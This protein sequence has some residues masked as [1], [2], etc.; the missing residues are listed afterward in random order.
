[1]AVRGVAAQRGGAHTILRRGAVER[2]AE[3]PGQ[4]GV[5][6]QVD[7]TGLSKD[8]HPTLFSARGREG[9]GQS[10]AA[11]RMPK[12]SDGAGTGNSPVAAADFGQ[13]G[14]AAAAATSIFGDAAAAATGLFG[15]VS[16]SVTNAA[17]ALPVAS[18]VPGG[19]PHWFQ[20]PSSVSAPA[21][22][23]PAPEHAISPNLEISLLG[24]EPTPSPALKATA[25]A[26]IDATPSPAP[27]KAPPTNPGPRTGK[28]QPVLPPARRELELP[29]AHA[30]TGTQGGTAGGLMVAAATLPPVPVAELA[31]TIFPN[32]HYSGQPGVHTHYAGQPAATAVTTPAVAPHTHYPGQPAVYAINTGSGSVDTPASRKPVHTPTSPQQQRFFFPPQPHQQQPRPTSESYHA[33]GQKGYVGINVTKQAPFIVLGASGL[34]DPKGILQGQTGYGNALVEPGDRL[35]RVDGHGIEFGGFKSLQHLLGGELGSVV[36][37]AFSRNNNHQFTIRALRHGGPSSSGGHLVNHH[38]VVLNE[39]VANE[40]V[41]EA[42]ANEKMR[43]TV[44]SFVNAAA[45]PA[46]V[47]EHG[48]EGQGRVQSE[49]V[50]LSQRLATMEREALDRKEREKEKERE[51]QKAWERSERERQLS[52][53][54]RQLEAATTPGAAQDQAHLSK[55][56]PSELFVSREAEKAEARV[57]VIL[58]RAEEERLAAEKAAAA[59]AAAS[60]AAAAAVVELE[61]KRQQM[62]REEAERTEKEAQERRRREE[63][64]RQDAARRKEREDKIDKQ[65][66]EA[67]R[68]AEQVQQEE[69]ARKNE[70]EARN[71]EEERLAAAKREEERLTAAKKEEEMLHKAEMEE[72]KKKQEE[73]RL[74]AVSIDESKTVECHKTEEQKEGG[75]N[76]RELNAMCCFSRM[77]SSY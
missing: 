39:A 37:L 15:T 17:A 3:Y 71:Q 32:T 26:L 8:E 36:E 69:A 16:T 13:V 23:A 53:R 1:V 40:K 14:Q 33:N 50:R 49:V 9:A 4:T 44:F 46:V 73:A 31:P 27:A 70:D 51:K 35:V 58:K 45:S 28:E 5:V 29:S 63:E 57:E 19:W 41:K 30:T 75:A 64:A 43:E 59:A 25:A 72:T 66:E 18:A 62:A 10:K 76:S 77:F 68:R 38:P 54:L 42:V 12:G 6:T 60:E 56:R 61:R 24:S 2:M 21:A 47:E 65:E 74:A 11:A 52:A 22:R 48:D 55:H 34:M 67:A 7:Q 20:S